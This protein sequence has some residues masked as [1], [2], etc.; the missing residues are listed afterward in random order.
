MDCIVHFEFN[1]WLFNRATNNF[2]DNSGFIDD[3]APNIIDYL[4]FWTYLDNFFSF[5]SF[6]FYFIL[7]ILF[8]QFIYN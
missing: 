1:D 2:I 6:F 3:T 5:L 7:R 4:L 8:F